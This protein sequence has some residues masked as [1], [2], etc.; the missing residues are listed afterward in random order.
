MPDEVP[1]PACDAVVNAKQPSPECGGPC[2]TCAFR[3]GTEANQTPHTVTL[4]RL[5]VEGLR[6]FDCHERPGLC[7]G[8]IAAV[9]LRGLPETEEDKRWAECCS[10]AADVLGLA[11]ADAEEEAVSELLAK[12]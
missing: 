8:Y 2:A 5:C 7:R 1:S 3:P 12:E 11:I 4:A 10:M 9:N 6:Y